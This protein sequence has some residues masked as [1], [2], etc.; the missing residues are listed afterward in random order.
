MRTLIL[1]TLVI[2]LSAIDSAKAQGINDVSVSI[3]QGNDIDIQSQQTQSVSGTGGAASPTGGRFLYS[4]L[5]MMFLR[6]GSA[7]GTNPRDYIYSGF[8]ANPSKS[9]TVSPQFYARETF[10]EKN[11]FSGT[12]VVDSYGSDVGVDLNTNT[13]LKIEPD[14]G[15]KYSSRDLVGTNTLR[16]NS[17]NGTLTLTQKIF[18]LVAITKHQP[19]ATFNLRDA[20]TDD[21]NKMQNDIYPNMD[22]KLGLVAAITASDLNTLVKGSRIKTSQDAYDVA[23]SVTFDFALSHEFTIS[24]VPSFDDTMISTS[25]GTSASGG[26]LQIQ[27]RNTYT[28]VP[29]ADT[30]ESF[31][32]TEYNS[33]LHDTSIEPLPPAAVPIAY[34]NWAKF[35]LSFSYDKVYD[36]QDPDN[37]R[38]VIARV[39]YSYEAFNAAYQAQNIIASVNIDF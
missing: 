35:G 9:I 29:S 13:G 7:G 19:G 36:D 16:T 14:F 23:P 22:I 34:Q 28:Y 38:H 11:S 18:P 25:T 33:L 6:P 39:E 37:K 5:K 15:Y 31:Q 24:L 32:L 30:T 17:Y 21:L 27:E 20:T 12:G 4:S 26:S 2:Y 1:A 3:D 8:V 10:N